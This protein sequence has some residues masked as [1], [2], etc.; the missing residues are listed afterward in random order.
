[1]NITLPDSDE[2]ALNFLTN[3]AFSKIDKTFNPKAHGKSTPGF[4]SAFWYNCP[5]GSAIFARLEANPVFLPLEEDGL[6]DLGRVVA[7]VREGNET[8]II[9]RDGS[10]MA[11]GFTPMTLARRFERFQEATRP[12]NPLEGPLKKRKGPIRS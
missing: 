10:V 2:V 5:V 3:I 4:Q 8:A 11:T 6:V 9:L 12:E 1:M 7:L